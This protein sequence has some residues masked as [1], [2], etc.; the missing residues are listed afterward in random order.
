MVT[1]ETSVVVA[2][3]KTSNTGTQWLAGSKRRT[4]RCIMLSSASSLQSVATSLIHTCWPSARRMPKT[5]LGWSYGEVSNE[6]RSRDK[7]V[8]YNAHEAGFTSVS[9]RGPVSCRMYPLDSKNPWRNDQKSSARSAACEIKGRASKVDMINELVSC[10]E[11]LLL[12]RVTMS[13]AGKAEG[14]ADKQTSKRGWSD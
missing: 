12:A 11:S 3:C 14:N 5:R 8:G 13:K 10:E 6:Y 2:S 1:K 7:R 4:P 9:L